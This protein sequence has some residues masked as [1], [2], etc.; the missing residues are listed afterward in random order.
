MKK[1]IIV[2]LLPLILLLGCPISDTKS[3]RPH[4]VGFNE[5]GE[6]FYNLQYQNENEFVLEL[7]KEVYLWNDEMNIIDDVNSYES[8]QAVMRALQTDKDRWSYIVEKT[9]ND[10]YF[11]DGEII[12]FGFYYIFVLQDDNTYLLRITSIQEDS[13]LYKAGVRKGDSFISIDDMS[14]LALDLEKVENLWWSLHDK[15]IDGNSH[16]FQI[17][18]NRIGLIDIS[19]TAGI[20]KIKTIH[21]KK[22]FKKENK[23][24]GYMTFSHFIRPSADELI[25]AFDF[26]NIN[27]I[28]ELIIDLRGNGGGL[29]DITSYFVDILIGN[30]QAGNISMTYLFNSNYE[31]ENMSYIISDVGYDFDFNKI[32]FLTDENTASASELLIN[33]LNPYLEVILIGSNT[34]GKPVGMYSFENGDYVYLPISFQLVNAFGYGDFFGGIGVDFNIYD[35]LSYDYGNPDDPIIAEALA[36]LGSGI[37]SNVRSISE[38]SRSFNPEIDGFKSIVGLF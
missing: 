3:S 30:K 33:S 19:A 14:L 36:Y 24:I 27:E 37:F 15:L 18:S 6:P 2:I 16:V 34:H 9:V 20:V 38:Y 13:E 17:E 28:D 1:R 21:K 23:N 10:A 29:V 35:D 26:F 8:P 22:I 4:K 11:T 7:M 5:N 12:G 31:D 25:E 32:V